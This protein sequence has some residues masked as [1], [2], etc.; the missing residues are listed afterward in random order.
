MTEAV[1]F[2]FHGV[3]SN[4]LKDTGTW[5]NFKQSNRPSG[6]TRKGEF[7]NSRLIFGECA[8][9]VLEFA[10]PIFKVLTSTRGQIITFRTGT[11]LVRGLSKWLGDPQFPPLFRLP[12]IVCC[13]HGYRTC[14][15]KKI[16]II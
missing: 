3:L 9:S 10:V 12:N 7:L 16:K 6:C 1:F 13:C 4:S 15:Q 14:I 11:S 2:R 5:S 8:D